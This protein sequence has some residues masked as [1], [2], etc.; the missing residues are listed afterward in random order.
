MSHWI[1]YNTL[2][3]QVCFICYFGDVFMAWHATVLT[4]LMKNPCC[5]G[6]VRQISQSRIRKETVP[7]Y[8]ASHKRYSLYLSLKDNRGSYCFAF[9]KTGTLCKRKLQS[10][11]RRAGKYSDLSSPIL[12][13][14]TKNLKT[15]TTSK[16]LCSNAWL[17]IKECFML[18]L[19]QCTSRGPP[20]QNSFLCPQ[21][22]PDNTVMERQGQKARDAAILNSAN[23]ALVRCDA[24]WEG[25]WV[26]TGWFTKSM[27][28]NIKQNVNRV[29]S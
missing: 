9:N 28:I 5:R 18:Y 6:D 2:Q 17:K 15:M 22:L 4:L 19:P 21:L 8:K 24:F 1:V 13:N 16:S 23:D 3:W 11:L 26:V 27:T 14:H 12:A 25:A 29:L 10:T 20:L 7:L